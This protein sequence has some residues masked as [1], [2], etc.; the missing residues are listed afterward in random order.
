MALTLSTGKP[1]DREDSL[2]YNNRGVEYDRQNNQ[3]K[4]LEDFKAAIKADPGFVLPRRNLC[5][6][7][8]HIG[9]LG[10]AEVDCA[11]ALKVAPNDDAT[12]SEMGFLRFVQGDYDA[13]LTSA[14]AA[15]RVRPS[16]NEAFNL[17]LYQFMKG[18]Y[19]E[20]ATQFRASIEKNPK[21][22]YA[23]MWLWMTEQR[24]GGRAGKRVSEY[25][26]VFA[27]QDW[28]APAFRMMSGIG[29]ADQVSLGIWKDAKDSERL[30]R[31]CEVYFYNAEGELANGLEDEAKADF[32]V[33]KYICPRGFVEYGGAL[34]ELKRMEAVKP[35]ARHPAASRPAATSKPSTKK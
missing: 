15:V 23:A 13:A 20:A 12:L 35:A 22:L 33:A 9:D 28:P 29:T 14:Q 32:G 25:P 7:H 4:A 10:Q 19:A 26:E 34:G 21:Y 2:V 17:G 27:V 30:G 3:A 11:E 18:D 5:N 8:L 16:R 24:P 31:F 6:T 1:M